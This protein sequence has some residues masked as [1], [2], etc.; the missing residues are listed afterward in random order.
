MP[1]NKFP[2]ICTAARRSRCPE[3]GKAIR[4]GDTVA[5]Y[6][7]LGIC[8]HKSSGHFADVVAVYAVE[9]WTQEGAEYATSD[10]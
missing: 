7:H 8:Y 10:T 5:L 9:E 4:K 6:P 3:T 1:R 2:F